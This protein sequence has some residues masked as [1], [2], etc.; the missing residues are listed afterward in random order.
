MALQSSGQ[1]K[2]SEIAA[3]LGVSGEPNLNLR[4]LSSG[5]FG[6]ISPRL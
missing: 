2:I 5:T 6:A 1:I 3:E 4:G